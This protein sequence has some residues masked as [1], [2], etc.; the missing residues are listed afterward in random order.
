MESEL[1]AKFDELAQRKGAANRS[2]AVRDLIRD[3]LVEQCWRRGTGEAMAAVI[4]L[5]D[6]HAHDLN[7]RLNHIQ[8]AHPHAVVSTLHV[9][10]SE[11]TCM[12]VVVLRGERQLLTEIGYRLIGT[13]GVLHGRLVPSTTGNDVGQSGHAKNH[14]GHAGDHAE[15]ASERR[16]ARKKRSRRQ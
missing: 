13:K 8:H 15:H 12:E 16:P 10:V 3:A 6:H 11:H 1:L 4:L 9:H 2:E 5:Y 14:T 7:K